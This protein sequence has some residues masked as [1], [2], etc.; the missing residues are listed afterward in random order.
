VLHQIFSTDAE[1]PNFPLNLRYLCDQRGSIS[2]ICRSIGINRQQFNKYLSGAHLPA[3]TNIKRIA[4]HFGLSADLLCGDHE[5]LV[6]LV[7]GNHFRLWDNLRRQP[8]L[9]RFLDTIT[10]VPRSDTDRLVG[11]YDRYQFSSIYEGQ[12]LKSAFCI[13]RNGDIL[14]H[15]YIERFPNESKRRAAEFVFKYHG[16]TFPIEGRIFTVDFEGAQHNE[17]TLGIYS[18][19]K[20]SCRQLVF[21]IGTG[22][23]ANM[24]RQ[25]YATKIALS[26]KHAGRITR[27]DIRALNV[28]PADDP[29]IPRE[30]LRYLR[31]GEDMIKPD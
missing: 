25:P 31:N 9:N 27:Q 30:V 3:S 5:Q 2:T 19:V 29:S 13:F 10:T 21:G 20:R 14:H 15:Y 16:F 24:L 28:L 12:I 17:M 23:A 1:F 4:N 18:L 6:A 22:I 26:Y 8:L 11:V 7:E